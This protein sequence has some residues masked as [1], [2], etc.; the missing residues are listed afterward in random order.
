VVELLLPP[1]RADAL[2]YSATMVDRVRDLA[3]EQ[4]DVEI[5]ALFNRDGLLSS[6]GKHFTAAMISW[7][8]YKHRI[9]GPLRPAGTLTITEV[10]ERYGVSMHV[11]YYWIERGHVSGHQRKPGAPYAITITD[12]TDRELTEWVATSS[13]IS[14]TQTA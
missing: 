2:R 1:N 11:V 3:R 12:R 4:D 10:C 14:Q 5:A 7:I 13:R 9:S 8:R 6:T